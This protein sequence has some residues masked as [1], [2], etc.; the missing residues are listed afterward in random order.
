MKTRRKK[1]RFLGF[2]SRIELDLP[3][4]VYEVNHYAYPHSSPEEAMRGDWE[5]V[6]KDFR[7]AIERAY[8]EAAR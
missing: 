7:I 3:V 1:R 5:R 6:G 4:K 8:D 2:L